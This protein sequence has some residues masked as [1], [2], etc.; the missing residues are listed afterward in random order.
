M[1]RL[2]VVVDKQRC[3][4]SAQCVFVAPDVFDQ[5]EEDGIVELITDEPEEALWEDVIEA[6]R[7]CPSRAITAE[8][9]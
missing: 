5:S 1:A 3:I 6:A 7:T 4:G 8:K 9:A 2:K